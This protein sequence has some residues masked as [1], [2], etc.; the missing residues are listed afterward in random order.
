[1][2]GF[3]LSLIATASLAGT[4]AQS[5]LFLTT[6]VKPNIMLMVDNSGSMKDVVQ[7]PPAP[8]D[9][10]IT[11]LAGK[12]GTDASNTLSAE[13]VTTTTTYITTTTTT[14]IQ[15]TTKTLC[16]DNGEEWKKDNNGVYKCKKA[17]KTITTTVKTPKTETVR[18][19]I[20]YTPSIPTDFLGYNSGKNKVVGKQCFAANLSY[21]INSPA[22]FAMPSTVV[23]D[24]QRANFL[25]WFYLEKL[26]QTKGGSA[27][28][29]IAKAA[30]VQLVNSLN[31]EVRVGLSTFN[32]ENGGA[33]LETINDLDAAKKTKLTDKIN[34]LGTPSFTPL[35]ETAA[36]IGRY[37]A[38]GNV[39]GLTLH[40]N[41]PGKTHK[42]LDEVLKNNLVNDTGSNAEFA[43]PPIQYSCQKSF[44]VMLTDGQPTKDQDITAPLQD[45]D[46]DCAVSPSPCLTTTPNYDLKKEF[47]S[48][49]GSFN[50]S[51]YLDDVAEAL[52]DMDLRPDLTKKADPDGVVRAKN[53]VT[54]Y[55]I[56]FADDTINPTKTEDL[57]NNGVLDAGEDVNSNGK[58]DR[59][60]PILKDT[61]VQG[62]GKF[63]YA[64]NA[65]ELSASLQLA[66][67]SILQQDSSASSVAANSS[68]YQTEALLFQALFRT[69]DWSGNLRAFNLLSEDTNHNGKLDK[70]TDVPK[71]VDV[72]EDTNGN[73]KLDAGMIGNVQWDA[74]SR[75]A[76]ADQRDIFSYD[77]VAGVGINF[78]W[79]GD[80]LN[81]AQKRALNSANLTA[82]SSPVLDYL[83]GVRDNEGTGAGEFRIRSSILGDIVNS[84][85]LFVADQDLGY[86]KL[87]GDEGATYA[88]HVAS[89]KNNTEIIYVGANDGMLHAFD[90]STGGSG[91]KEVF[92]YVPNSVISAELAS[93]TDQNY[94]HHYFVDGAPQ[95][96]DAYFD[97][98]WHAVLLG[99]MGAGGT[100][101]VANADDGGKLLT[102]TGG[103]A[104]FALDITNP[105]AFDNTHVLWEFSSRHDADLGYTIP[106]PSVVRMANGSWAAIVAN[107]YNSAKGTAALFFLDVKTGLPIKVTAGLADKITA[108]TSG[109]NGLSSPTPV[110][111]DGDKIVDYIYAGDLKGN[112]WKFDVSNADPAKW[113]VATLFAAKD[114]LGAAQPITSKPAV[115]K[116]TSTDQ[117]SGYMVYFG[118]GKYFESGDHAGSATSQVQTFYGIWD[119]CDK[120]NAASCSSAV[121]GRTDLQQQTITHEL[122]VDKKQLDGSIKVNPVRVTTACEVAY[123]TAP[124]ALPPCTGA[125]N[126]KG[127]F[128]DLI[129]PT[130]IAQGERVVNNAVVRHDTVIF[131]TL[132]PTSTPC[133][134]SGR[135]WLMEVQLTGS[136][137][138]GTPFDLNRDGKFNDDDLIKLPDGTVVGATGVGFDDIVESPVIV[139][140]EDGRD[141]KYFNH[142]GASIGDVG[143][144][145]PLG[146][147]CA[148][149]PC[150]TPPIPGK[151]MS[152]RQLR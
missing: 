75:M 99:S 23:T 102:G 104:V 105:T 43:V 125:T 53:N 36:G 130:G 145:V 32:G 95:Y 113:G 67:E 29:D 31:S 119:Q 137:F 144:K 123:G 139:N 111:S 86:D 68:Q 34:A 63:F 96:G 13:T 22:G 109:G 18:T 17:T 149:P 11:Y 27:R 138:V 57:N 48:S 152:W 98:A 4:V 78:S 26:G 84:D 143:N 142:S 131:T 121:S 124:S 55:T 127:W 94:I 10:T 120:T 80:G 91:G 85:P 44:N 140:T 21:T 132:I 38:T 106:Q 39:G 76:A 92:A 150:T 5:P 54:T 37:Y 134:P 24:A 64:A 19:P 47:A 49:A 35:A 41:G 42:T 30:A 65:S 72:S 118:T 70:P 126:R 133:E 15:L 7:T 151:R 87:G 40:P 146:G 3:G 141:S 8:Y 1:M 110:D 12:C 71:I 69:S 28:I 62:G 100:T 90:A 114:A 129:P 52:Y 117:K 101:A 135:S 59:N 108:D 46:G 58:I 79:G 116:A 14:T 81:K 97:G 82:A 60:N 2:L 61:A 51:D 148:T 115:A 25:N 112:L 147:G 73:G 88:N 93:L 122:S 56:G 83:R 128:M 66:V 6:N 107:G 20:T 16:E 74:A 50:T 33:L 9:P 103:R 77:P 89:K 136:R 45:Y